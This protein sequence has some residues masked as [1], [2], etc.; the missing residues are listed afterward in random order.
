MHALPLSEI[1]AREETGEERRLRE[2]RGAKVEEEGGV[3]QG[4]EG[5][6][7]MGYHRRLEPGH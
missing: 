3:G 1:E 4:G 6:E 5:R 2:G 7:G